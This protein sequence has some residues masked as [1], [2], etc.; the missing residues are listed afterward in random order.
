[1]VISAVFR[2]IRSRGLTPPAS[3]EARK[4]AA[5]HNRTDRMIFL[6]II[7]LSMRQRPGHHCPGLPVPAL[8][9]HR[10]N[11]FIAVNII[12]QKLEHH[13]FCKSSDSAQIKG[14]AVVH[15]S[16]VNLEILNHAAHR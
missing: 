12:F 5:R 3:H 7:L 9:P 6:F 1:M 13:F 8:K 2:M 14:K 10:E 11:E 16:A 4:T 15:D